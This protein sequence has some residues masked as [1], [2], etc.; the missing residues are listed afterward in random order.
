M[1]YMLHCYACLKD[2][3]NVYTPHVTKQAGEIEHLYETIESTINSA[4]GDGGPCQL[5]KFS[6]FVR[7]NIA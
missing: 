3:C 4:G 6:A 1:S 2:A 5:L 7:P